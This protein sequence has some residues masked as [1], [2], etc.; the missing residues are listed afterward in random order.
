MTRLAQA[1]YAGHLGVSK[2]FHRTKQTVYCPGF[3]TNSVNLLQIVKQAS[4]L[5]Q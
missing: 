3:I 2:C 5:C 4:V 1:N